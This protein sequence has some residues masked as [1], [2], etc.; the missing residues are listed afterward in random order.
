MT[1]PITP[2]HTLM[3]SLDQFTRELVKSPLTIQ[4]YRADVQQFIHWMAENDCTVTGAHQVERSH[5]TEYL[6]YLANDKGYTGATR[7]RKLVSLQVFFSYLVKAGVIPHSP[8]A[9]IDRPRKEQK[10]MH[11]LRPDEY[12]R[13]LAEAA[14]DP[15]DYCIFQVFLHTGIRVSELVVLYLSDL[16]LEQ[17]T[18]IIHGKGNRERVIPLEKKP[19]QAL[20]LYLGHRP[21]NTDP[22]V[23]LN[24]KGEGL[25]IRGVRKIVDKYVKQAG[26]TKIISCHGLRRTCLSSRAA[27][28]MNAF[29]IQKLAG[30]ARMETTRI[31]VQLST[32]DLR[33]AM[34]TANI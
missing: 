15:R 10:T 1:A 33:Q 3:S 5:I 13:V 12:S 31:Y 32:E 4:A 24:Y 25:S 8:A 11:Y 23:F 14:G 20:K 30:H 26:I 19:F 2:H 6:K 28:N 22:H 7:A 17:K 27:R 9:T 29:A 21:K 18:V 16:D 34:E